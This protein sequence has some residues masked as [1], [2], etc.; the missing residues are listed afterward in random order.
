MRLS[1]CNLK[2]TDLII[3]NTITQLKELDISYGEFDNFGVYNLTDLIELTYLDISH[4]NYIT[5]NILDILFKLK[6]LHV[7]KINDSPGIKEEVLPILDTFHCLSELYINPQ[8][9]ILHEDIS[10]SF[11][12]Y[13]SQIDIF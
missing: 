12:I 2:N 1:N 8:T 7:L 10:I 4:N 6:R 3:I 13:S 11:N 9:F 5:S